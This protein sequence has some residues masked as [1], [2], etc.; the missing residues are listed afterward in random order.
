MTLKKSYQDTVTETFHSKAELIDFLDQKN[1]ANVIN[2]WICE[3]TNGSFKDFIN[4]DDIPEE[5]VMIL[6]NAIYF[7]GTWP[8]PFIKS[9]YP[10][11]FYL[12]KLEKVKTNYIE[13]QGVF[14][15]GNIDDTLIIDLPYNGTN[16]KM[17]IILPPKVDGLKDLESKLS[18]TFLKQL[19]DSMIDE[20]IEVII[21]KFKIDFKIKLKEPLKKVRY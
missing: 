18:R 21:P 13:N 20:D 3:Q 11:E 17:T 7:K 8:V 5:T 19:L 2:N 1:A 4:P 16:I 9:Q 12:N 14:K 15:Y 6:L 10:F